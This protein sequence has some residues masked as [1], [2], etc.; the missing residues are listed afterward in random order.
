M[1]D[2]QLGRVAYS[3]YGSVTENKN[4]QGLPMPAWEDLTDT[5]RSAWMAA[6]SAAIHAFGEPWRAKFSVDVEEE[7][8][9]F[10]E[11]HTLR[12]C[13]TM[14]QKLCYKKEPHKTHDWTLPGDP[15]GTEFHCAGRAE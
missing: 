2:E 4:Y 12:D 1:D 5:I 11:G 13:D 8:P 6:A 9:E 10:P 14:S 3:A 15:Y 7:L